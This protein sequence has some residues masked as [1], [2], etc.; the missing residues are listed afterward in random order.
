MF[1][2]EVKAGPQ[3]NR[4]RKR[5]ETLKKCSLKMLQMY[6]LVFGRAANKQIDSPIV[7]RQSSLRASSFEQLKDPRLIGS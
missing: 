3:W 2:S 1:G 5:Q 6:E 7:G 4:E